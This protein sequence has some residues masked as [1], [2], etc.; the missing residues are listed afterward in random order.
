MDSKRK[1]ITLAFFAL[2]ASSVTLY[3]GTGLRPIWRLVLAGPCPVLLVYQ[4]VSRKVAVA[5]AF[6]ACTWA[7]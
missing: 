5:V 3:F 6:L 4:R 1:A 7:I 2:V